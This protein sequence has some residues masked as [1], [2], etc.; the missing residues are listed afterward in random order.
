MTMKD[1]HHLV[2]RH[3]GGTDADGLVEVTKTQHAM[4]HFC[5]YQLWG[6]PYDKLAWHMIAGQI[7]KEEGRRIA[8]SIANK[9]K[10]YGEETRE[11]IRQARL[12]RSTI[13]ED[14]RRRQREATIRN[15]TGNKLSQDT[16]ELLR[17]KASKRRCLCITTGVVYESARAAARE[18]GLCYGR[19]K[20]CASGALRKNGNRKALSVKGYSFVYCD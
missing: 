11:K 6:N 10:V 1:K 2:P 17:A 5:E 9:G 15:K 14:G 4:F 7:G 16:K 19:V 20:S 8:S 3:R 13:T 12:G 18:L